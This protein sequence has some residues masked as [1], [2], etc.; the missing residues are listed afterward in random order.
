[1]SKTQGYKVVHNEGEGGAI[2]LTKD[3]AKRANSVN[4]EEY[5][6]LQQLRKDYGGYL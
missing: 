4:S 2:Y 3:F 1:M 6:I 5:N